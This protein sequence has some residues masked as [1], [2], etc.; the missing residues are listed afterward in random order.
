MTFEWKIIFIV[1]SIGLLLKNFLL[2][3]GGKE[4]KIES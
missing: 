3:S 2:S 4:L 1:W